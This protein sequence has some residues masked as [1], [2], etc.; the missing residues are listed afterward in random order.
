MIRGFESHFLLLK[1]K[2]T[3]NDPSDVDVASRTAAYGALLDTQYWHGRVAVEVDRSADSSIF[4]S[5]GKHRHHLDPPPPLFFFYFI[6][7]FIFLPIAIPRQPTRR[8]GVGEGNA[9]THPHI[10][11]CTR[12]A[13]CCRQH[14]VKQLLETGN[15]SLFFFFTTLNLKPGLPQLVYTPP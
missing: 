6:F 1:K 11:Y 4:G 10:L 15:S 7:L 5:R 2:T 9:R 13:G 12:C 8:K 3:K 14:E